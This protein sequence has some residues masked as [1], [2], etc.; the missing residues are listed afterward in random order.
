MHFE[1][2]ANSH[3]FESE[4][5]LHGSVNN[6]CNKISLSKVVLIALLSKFIKNGTKIHN[7][8]AGTSQQQYHQEWI[9]G[10][11]F[12]KEI[13]LLFHNNHWFFFITHLD[14]LVNVKVH[15]P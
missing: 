3:T 8:T 10:T 6:Q 1:S 13:V 11:I 5:I 14:T 2:S 9:F 4:S 15:D 7:S 12:D